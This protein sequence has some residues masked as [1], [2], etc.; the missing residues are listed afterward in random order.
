MG[1]E[2]RINQ[3]IVIL[4]GNAIKFTPENGEINLSVFAIVT[5]NGIISLQFEITDTGIG[6]REEK[7][8][9]IFN[10]FEQADGGLS[11]K[12]GGIGLGLPLSKRII[13]MMGGTIYFESSPEIG[14][15]FIFT[16][17]MSIPLS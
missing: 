9:T 14:S 3:V 1:D 8:D 7:H 12:H 17:K 13:E 10:I 11:R 6:I 15:T 4:L 2:K 5:E 16:C